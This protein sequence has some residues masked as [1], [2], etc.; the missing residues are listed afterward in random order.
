MKATLEIRQ[1]V[2]PWVEASLARILIG[3]SGGTDSMALAIATLAE[4]KQANIDVV[5][6]IVDHQLQAESTAVALRTKETLLLNGCTLVEVYPV[7]VVVTDGLESSARRARYGAFDHAI[8]TFN[9]DYF[10]LGHTKNDQA[11]TV[12]LGLARGSGTRSLSGIAVENGSF[13][14]PLLEVARERTV[15]ACEENGIIPWIDPHN[16]DSKYLR[17]K[18]RDT[19][20]PVMEE[21][22][23]PGISDGLARSAR[24]LREDADALDQIA[25]ELFETL[26]SANIEVEALS[27]SPKAIRSRVLRLAIYAAGAPSGT[28]GADHLASVEALITGW[29]GQGV[30]SLPGGVKVERISGRL[31]LS[32]TDQRNTTYKEEHSGPGKI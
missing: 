23:G 15:A 18:V 4:A 29:R 24:I 8:A 32:R 6:I 2:R 20:L 26:D 17:V 22:L 1:A 10:F 31:S 13:V 11:E 5:A 30:V 9:P 21:Q 25:S 16:S 3:V 7:D 14:R 28:L 12:L 19:V 27:R